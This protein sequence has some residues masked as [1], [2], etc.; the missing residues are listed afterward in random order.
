MNTFK[1]MI[2]NRLLGVMVLA[3]AAACATGCDQ[4]SLL[5]GLMSLQQPSFLQPGLLG[6]LGALDFDDYGGYGDFGGFDDYGW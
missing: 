3:G 2:R 1:K 4:L 6:G 5:Q